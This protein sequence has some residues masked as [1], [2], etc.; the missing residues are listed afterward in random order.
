MKLIHRRKHKHKINI[1]YKF[2]SL[3]KEEEYSSTEN[4]L[5]IPYINNDPRSL[6]QR[7]DAILV[8]CCPLMIGLSSETEETIPLLTYRSIILPKH[9]SIN[10]LILKILTSS[11]PI[12]GNIHVM[13]GRSMSFLLFAGR[14]AYS[15][16]FF[17]KLDSAQRS[18]PVNHISLTRYSFRMPSIDKWHGN[19]HLLPTIL[20]WSCKGNTLFANVFRN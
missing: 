3:H 11:I 13:P 17:G 12:N 18:S 8:L 19:S 9:G 1:Y 20:I 4:R 14:G 16:K 6:L 10:R 15:K 2:F 5:F 7:L